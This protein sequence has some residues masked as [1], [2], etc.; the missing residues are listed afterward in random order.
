MT[1]E[2]FEHFGYG[3][4]PKEVEKVEHRVQ[5]WPKWVH[6]EVLNRGVAVRSREEEL[7]HCPE[8]H[9]AEV[10]KEEAKAPTTAL[11]Q[12][13]QPQLKPPLLAKP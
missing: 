11:N 2:H 3:I 5:E 7:H 4:L 8:H 13:P 6:S 12:P 10:K 1:H 9:A